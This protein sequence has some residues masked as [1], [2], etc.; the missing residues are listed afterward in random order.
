M[1]QKYNSKEKKIRYYIENLLSSLL[2]CDIILNNNSN[3]NIGIVV[4]FYNISRNTEAGDSRP[5]SV[6]KRVPSLFGIQSEN[7][8]QKFITIIGLI[9]N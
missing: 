7:M 5:A 1:N 4:H 8:F 9:N 6:M 3:N 2:L